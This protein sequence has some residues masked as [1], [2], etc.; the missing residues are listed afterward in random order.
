[1]SSDSCRHSAY[2]IVAMAGCTI[3]IDV[4]PFESTLPNEVS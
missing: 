2:G 1:M 3:G 4:S